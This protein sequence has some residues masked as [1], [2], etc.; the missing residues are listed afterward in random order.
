MLRCQAA[1]LHALAR[2]LPCT[3]AS[4]R[5]P[6][7]LLIAG[8]SL[9]QVACGGAEFVLGG[10]DDSGSGL[11]GSPGKDATAPLDGG[12]VEDAGG[13]GGDAAGPK[14]AG[15]GKDAAMPGDAGDAGV[16]PRDAGTP[17][18][19]GDGGFACP[20]PDV[21]AIFC[22]GFDK[23][24]GPPWDWSSAP[25]TPKGTD[26]VD[27][28]DFLS[29]P[30]G[31]AAS[32]SLLLKTDNETLAYV[33]K[34]LSSM[35]EHIDFTFHVLVKTYDALDNPSIPIGQLTISPSTTAAFSADVVLTKGQLALMQTHTGVDGGLQTESVGVG[36]LAT[37]KWAE[38][39]M[40][41]DRP[42][43]PAIWTI[44]VLVNG[45]SQLLAQAAANPSDS[46]LEVDVGILGVLPTS[47][48]NAITFDNVTVR[49][50]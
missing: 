6:V 25:F 47:T 19:A 28:T 27:T 4:M 36:P 45:T 26:A 30:N 5:R 16:Q 34:S 40:V 22:S 38:L 7:C 9:L 49:A 37:G 24:S 2:R 21:T 23:E 13:G 11:D 35:A 12:G 44:N 48:A 10:A 20:S 14:D 41:L 32:N 1:G 33:G 42:Q 50:Y 43:S 8:F 15:G 3:I 17:I 46:D 31:F 29:P 18:D 39:E